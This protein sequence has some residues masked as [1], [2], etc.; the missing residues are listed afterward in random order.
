MTVPVPPECR[1]TVLQA[2]SRLTTDPTN[3]QAVAINASPILDWLQEAPDDEDLRLRHRALLRHYCNTRVLVEPDDD[4]HRLLDGA[5]V[6]YA[7]LTAEP[8]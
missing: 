7:F 8:G 4:P 6:F 3:P 2:A 5:R 1:M